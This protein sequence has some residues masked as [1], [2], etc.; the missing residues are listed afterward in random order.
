MNENENFRI[1]S[2]GP[3]AKRSRKAARLVAAA[4]RS[5]F[6]LG[7]RMFL[8]RYDLCAI[9]VKSNIQVLAVRCRG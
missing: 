4:A 7:N 6:T 9:D 8:L 3:P 5:G 1:R 2:R